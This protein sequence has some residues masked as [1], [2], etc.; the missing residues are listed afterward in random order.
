M[1]SNAGS[2]GRFSDRESCGFVGHNDAS[3]FPTMKKTFRGWMTCLDK[4]NKVMRTLARGD[5]GRLRNWRTIQ[6]RGCRLIRLRD[7]YSRQIKN[8]TAKSKTVS[9]TTRIE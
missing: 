2:V 7:R 3:N 5:R 6:T 4:K 9:R 8:A 1:S